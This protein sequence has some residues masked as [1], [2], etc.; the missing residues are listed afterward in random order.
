M[1]EK[2]KNSNSAVRYHS[3][4][5][6]A[7]ERDIQEVMHNHANSIRSFAYMYHDKDITDLHYHLLVRTYDAWTPR[8]INKWFDYIKLNK[9][10]NTFC[11]PAG[12]IESLRTYI[13][14]KDLESIEA[15]KATYELD[16][17]KDF[18]LFAEYTEKDSCDNTYEIIN[19]MLKGVNTR[20][21]VRRYGKQLIYHYSQFLAVV[22]KIKD[23]E[24][25]EAIYSDPDYKKPYVYDQ[26]KLKPIPL[27]NID[28]ED[29]LNK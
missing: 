10:V 7:S 11:E 8:Q 14:H 16:Q 12:S 17:I 9:G 18:G 29:V 27:D 6:Y 5:T 15:G 13:Q 3:F 2:K 28:I 24:A 26:T 1:A 21:L 19:A 20:M 22:D 23:E 4:V 25:Y